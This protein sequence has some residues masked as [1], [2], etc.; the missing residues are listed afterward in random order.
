MNGFLFCHQMHE[1]IAQDGSFA[2][3][4]QYNE[5]DPPR[6]QVQMVD[7][8]DKTGHGNDR[9]VDLNVPFKIRYVRFMVHILE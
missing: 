1:K 9:K 5:G 4:N 6:P 8:K 3:R 2:D 7:E